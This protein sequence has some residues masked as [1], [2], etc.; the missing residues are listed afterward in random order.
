MGQGPLSPSNVVHQILIFHFHYLSEI[1]CVHVCTDI[2]H[3]KD[4]KAARSSADFVYS[5]VSQRPLTV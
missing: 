2:Q 1:Y 4:R 3:M 5:N